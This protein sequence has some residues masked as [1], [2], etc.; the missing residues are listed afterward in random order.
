MNILN[1]NNNKKIKIQLH[2]ELINYKNQNLM[3]ILDKKI[4]YIN[5]NNNNITQLER[6]KTIFEIFKIIENNIDTLNKMKLNNFIKTFI[7]VSQRIKKEIHS[8]I[9]EHKAEKLPWNKKKINILN[10]I[11]DCIDKIEF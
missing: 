2:D 10:K 3:K 9:K 4:N 7:I 5:N 1:E 6:Y 11:N 8:S